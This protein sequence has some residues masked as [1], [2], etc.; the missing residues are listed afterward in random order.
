MKTTDSKQKTNAQNI[1][2]ILLI[3]AGI[4]TAG[5]FTSEM[6]EG[7]ILA[8]ATSFVCLFFSGL[9][10]GILIKF[11]GLKDKVIN[12]IP[13]EIEISTKKTNF[14][15]AEIV[16][17]ID[18]MKL[19]GIYLFKNEIRWKKLE[20]KENE[21]LTL[22]TNTHVSLLGDLEVSKQKTYQDIPIND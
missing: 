6:G 2:I 10:F 15:T 22:D 3:A 19:K 11:N 21:S 13:E 5:F 4:F 1:G 18:G 9:S 14:I 16:A 7:K 12:T 17:V 20:F 8:F